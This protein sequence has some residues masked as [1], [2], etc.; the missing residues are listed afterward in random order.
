MDKMLGQD[1]LVIPAYNPDQRLYDLINEV[2]VYFP[3]IVVVNDGS[4]A[5]TLPIFNQLSFDNVK[6][7]THD[8]NQGVGAAYKTAINYIYQHTQNNK[9]IGMIT[10]DADGQHLVDD[11]VKVTQCLNQN[12]TKVIIG[13]RTF[14]KD[15]P[16]R[17]FIGNRSMCWIVK[18]VFRRDI[19]DCQS[20][21]RAIPYQYMRVYLETKQNRFDF[22]IASLLNFFKNKIPVVSEPIKTV[23][24]DDNKS[25][26]FRPIKD[27]YE[28]IKVI[29][30]YWFKTV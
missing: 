24:I 25:S 6:I 3:Q 29:L 11:I 12:P 19:A 27:S 4:K 30:Q 21:L 15:I 13:A 5:D 22:V 8:T 28:T 9:I 10:A 23:Y 14:T 16:L 18:I 26:H 2:R 1:W 20:G 7:L 17:S